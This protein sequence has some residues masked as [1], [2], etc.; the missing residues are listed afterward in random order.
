MKK[1]RPNFAG[2]R[3]VAFENRR[4]GELQSLIEGHGGV[5]T[6]VPCLQEVP[7]HPNPDL[8]TFERAL[9]SGEIGVTIFLSASGVRLL[10][11]EIETRL[12]REVWTGALQKTVVV[13]RGP[14][15]VSALRELRVPV[16]LPAAAPHTWREVIGI[17][18]EKKIPLKQ[19]LIAVQE[20][21]MM[22]RSLL[23]ALLARG[24]RPMRVPLY[25]WALPDDLSPL[26][27]AIE[28]IADKQFDVALFTTGTQVW[29][30]F[31]VATKIGLEDE[32]RAGLR[33]LV[34]ASIGPAT[35]E[36]LREFDLEAD[37][38]PE[39]PQL[40]S[41]V[42][43]AALHAGARLKAKYSVLKC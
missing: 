37:L 27:R 21:G 13:A 23:K 19:R 9:L 7:L 30:L 15:A 32:L 14:K 40:N 31:R 16:A 1:R 36:A 11:A 34:I 5:P 4:S 42:Q 12:P 26:R 10:C 41:L 8:Q 20:Y 38:T 24:A 3:V 29:H 39:Q 43:I 25:K 28:A 6:L 2:L 33:A 22:N 18:D 17:L 35:N